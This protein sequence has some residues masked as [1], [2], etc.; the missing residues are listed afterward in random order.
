MSQILV[1]R[2]QQ[3][4]KFQLTNSKW[5]GKLTTLSKVERQFTMTKIQNPKQ[6]ALDLI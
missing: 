6:L 2:L 5:F 4:T 3:I 1:F